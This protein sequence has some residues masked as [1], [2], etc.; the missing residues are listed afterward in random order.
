MSFSVSS[1]SES[2][3]NNNRSGVKPRVRS[4]LTS[5][6]RRKEL[7]ERDIIINLGL[8]PDEK[9]AISDQIIYYYFL[10]LVDDGIVG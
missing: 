6:R 9:G 10:C 2:E 7:M 4:R 8:D 1:K 3:E 5:I